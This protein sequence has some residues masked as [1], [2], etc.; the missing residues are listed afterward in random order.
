MT[1]DDWTAVKTITAGAL[2]L[3]P[4]ERDVYVTSRCGS[5]AFLRV[6]VQSLLESIAA[7]A[8]LYENPVFPATLFSPRSPRTANLSIRSSAAA[9]VPTA[10]CRR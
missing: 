9:S 10:W 7:S 4:S 2:A 6:E 8:N 3:P 5:D 1:R